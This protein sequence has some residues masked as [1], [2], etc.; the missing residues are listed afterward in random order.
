LVG[1]IEPRKGH[2]Q[3][4]EAFEYL[5]DKGMDIH[6]VIVG[7][8]GWVG[9]PDAQRRTI[10]EIIHRLETHPQRNQRLFWFKEASDL[11]LETLYRQAD[12]LIAASEDEGFG[13]PLI[14]A[15]HYALPIIA[16][17][18]PVFHEVASEYASY[19]PNN[20][21]ARSLAKALAQWLEEYQKGTHILSEGMPHISWKKS[22][23]LLLDVLVD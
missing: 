7:K 17:D 12:V 15:A 18:I 1:T 3:T 2:L 22:A 8:E 10:P 14:E 5:W 9:L 11:F 19:F 21:N 6:L 4:L 16:R 13:L 20:R 23:R